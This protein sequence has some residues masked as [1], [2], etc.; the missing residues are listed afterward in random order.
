M[1][2]NI[3]VEIKDGIVDIQNLDAHSSGI[4]IA[5][6]FKNGT[7]RSVSYA[8]KL[9]RETGNYNVYLVDLDQNMNNLDMKQ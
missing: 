8:I 7:F 2:H 9:Y 5:C 6:C 3:M 4:L 1:S